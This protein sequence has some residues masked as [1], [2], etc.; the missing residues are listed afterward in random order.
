M[1]EPTDT[2]MG[3]NIDPLH[4]DR[5]TNADRDAG[6]SRSA[7]GSPAT[8]ENEQKINLDHVPPGTTSNPP[9]DRSYAAVC[10][11]LP[12]GKKERQK[13]IAKQLAAGTEG[14][15]WFEKEN[16]LD[17]LFSHIPD[18]HLIGIRF[19]K[20][21]VNPAEVAQAVDKT[22]TPPKAVGIFFSPGVVFVSFA[23][24]AARQE[25]LSQ[26]LPFGDASLPIFPVV[27]STGSRVTI[28]SDYIPISNADERRALLQDLFQEH[29]KIVHFT[30]IRRK[31]SGLT[32]PQTIFELELHE[33]A[34]SDMRIPRVAAVKG[35]N[36]LFAWSGPDFCYRCGS[37]VHVKDF[38]S[39]PNDYVLADKPALKEPIMA[40]VHRDP[41]TL[42][43]PRKSRDDKTETKAKVGTPAPTKA[44]PAPLAQGKGNNGAARRKDGSWCDE[45]PGSRNRKRGQRSAKQGEGSS[46]ASESETTQG[47]PTKRHAHL[48]LKESNSDHNNS[49]GKKNSPPVADENASSSA[50][51]L[52]SDTAGARPVA[53]PTATGSTPPVKPSKDAVGGVAGSAT[54]TTRA[55]GSGQTKEVTDASAKNVENLGAVQGDQE[56]A[57]ESNDQIKPTDTVNTNNSDGADTT[58]PAETQKQGEEDDEEDGEDEAMPE[59]PGV[60]AGVTTEATVSEG[61]ADSVTPPGEDNEVFVED[62]GTDANMK[63]AKTDKELVLEKTHAQH[64]K[65][66]LT[67]AMNK[68]LPGSKRKG[69]RK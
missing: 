55:S 27:R 50:T 54:A 8:A 67:L 19:D 23:D 44:A 45:Q 20:N 16:G 63:T 65:D 6:A 58:P 61:P 37:D 14:M 21:T 32:T 38:C 17:V 68:P 11:P 69:T 51:T 24:E 64:K 12:P 48:P 9:T 62:D 22:F 26:V 43:L 39:M 33:D 60:A 34:T 49:T 52:G 35:V 28:R 42:P 5:G 47:P 4:S 46:S 1:A 59:A 18:P 53:A 29:G 30:I 31:N 57:T 66:Q 41:D 3:G 25:A 40:R 13:E 2:A 7:S 15:D 36:C 56:M 10:F